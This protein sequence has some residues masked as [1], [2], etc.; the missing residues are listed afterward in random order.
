MNRGNWERQKKYEDDM[1]EYNYNMYIWEHTHIC[2]KCNHRFIVEETPR[3]ASF[4]IESQLGNLKSADKTI[5][6][7]PFAPANIDEFL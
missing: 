3:P 2:W 1:E 5:A 4:K 6:S 7:L